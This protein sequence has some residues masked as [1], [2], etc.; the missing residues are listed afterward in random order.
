MTYLRVAGLWKQLATV[1]QSSGDNLP[2]WL[3]SQ[4]GLQLSD[5]GHLGSARL[6]APPDPV[7]G[8]GLGDLLDAPNAC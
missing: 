6:S 2:L 3:T 8:H 4:N 1:V 7:C 5:L